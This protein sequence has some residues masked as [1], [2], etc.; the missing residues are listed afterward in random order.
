MQGHGQYIFP[1]LIGQQS[2]SHIPASE[3]DQIDRSLFSHALSRIIWSLL[4]EVDSDDSMSSG[5]CGVHLGSGHGSVPGTLLFL[6][7]DL[8]IAVHSSGCQ[9]LNCM[10]KSRW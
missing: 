5:A 8:S 6:C 3:I 10:K 1:G 9:L 2:S 4:C 7:F